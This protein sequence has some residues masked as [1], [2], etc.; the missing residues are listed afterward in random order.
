MS[1]HVVC[2]ESDS[3]LCVQA[4]NHSQ[5]NHLEV[6]HILED[7]RT[8]LLARSGF[9]IQFVKRQANKVAHLMAR[10]PCS[11]DCPNI[12]TSPPD[13]LLETLLHDV[14]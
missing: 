11:L 8:T 6:G 14:A 12:L 9:S 5:E 13:L 4:I 10:L 7:F 1:H 3:L 2:I